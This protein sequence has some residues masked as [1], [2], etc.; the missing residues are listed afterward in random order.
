MSSSGPTTPVIE[1][2]PRKGERQTNM[3]ERALQSR[4]RQQEILSEFGV[5]ALKVIPLMELLNAAVRLA[6]EGLEAEF[7]KVLEYIPTE[8]RLLVKAGIGWHAGL[9]GTAALGA[10]L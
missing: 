5:T 10:A 3:N 9:V 8:N 7:C 1:C 4:I 6:A 2:S